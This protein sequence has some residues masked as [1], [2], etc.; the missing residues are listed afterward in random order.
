MITDVT[1]R[2]RAER[3]M[4]RARDEAMAAARAKDDFLAALSHE[5]RTPL[6]PVLLVASAAAADPGLSAD[7]R[8]DFATIAKNALLEARL[9]D[10]LLDLTRITRGKMTLDLKTVDVHAVLEDAVATVRADLAEKNLT[11]ILECGAAN[12]AA[13]ADSARLQQVFWN[14]LKNAVKFT[15]AKG[16]IRV[17]TRSLTESNEMTV[18]VTDSG[19][20][21][22]SEE[23]DRVFQAFSQGDHAGG[24]GS[25]RFG[26]LG[27]GWRFPKC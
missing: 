3:E 20:G 8:A 19:I 6:S 13:D 9:I 11:L 4:L 15:P 5:L 10:D 7:V 24:S 21:M 18:T 22:T 14:V 2:K 26:G 23:L 16:R 12:H 17:E 27:L 25:H 1:A